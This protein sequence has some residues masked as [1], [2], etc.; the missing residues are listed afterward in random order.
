VKTITSFLN[1][2]EDVELIDR[3]ICVDDNSSNADR[4]EMQRLFPFFEF[5]WK[6][7]EEK[8]HARSM[9]IIRQAVRTPFL[10]HLEDDWH[11]FVK[12]KYIEPAIEIL[13]EAP[14][15]GQVLFNRN[16][17]EVLEQRDLP[18]GFRC[19]SWE[20]AYRYRIHEHYE[21]T[22]E[23]YR[24]FHQAHQ[25]RSSCAYW[26][27]YS[28]QPSVLKYKVFE[29]VGPYDETAGH[30]ELEY[31]RRYVRAGMRS[32]FFDGIYCLH[33][34]RLTSERGDAS[35]PNAYELNQMVQFE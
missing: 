29:R 25:W 28:L 9:N 16:Y 2:C 15:L 19:F 30:F 7:P 1:T 3:W 18:G 14:D 34:G 4:Q 24:R 17:A 35:K 11:F 12:R 21:P 31:A 10:V 26:P 5:I 13:T 8:G 20:H 23:E 33:I 6:G 32:A 27:H 22:S